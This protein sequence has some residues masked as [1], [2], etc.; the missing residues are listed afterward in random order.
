MRKLVSVYDASRILAIGKTKVQYLV[1]AGTL[2]SVKIG[3]RRLI[4]VDSIND[5]MGEAA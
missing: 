2:A 5:I 4:V 3:G 1:N